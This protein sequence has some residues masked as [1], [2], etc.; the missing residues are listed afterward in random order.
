MGDTHSNTTWWGSVVRPAIRDVR[1]NAV[2][3][4]GD[5]GYWPDHDEGRAFLAEVSDSL[6]AVG[7][8][9]WFVDG[10]HEQHDRLSPRTSPHRVY[11][12]VHHLPRS[13][14]WTWESI[15]F[16]ALGGAVSPDR[17]N[18]TE[19][20]DWFES[21]RITDADLVRLGVG[22]LD[23]LVTHDAPSWCRLQAPNAPSAKVDRDTRKNRALVDRAIT[24]TAPALVLHG[25]WHLAHV[26]L[27]DPARQRPAVLGMGADGHR[28]TSVA[29][30]DVC[31]LDPS[32]RALTWSI[33]AIV[34]T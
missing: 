8:S 9:L 17:E 27:A 32:T 11:P 2:L 19:G 7:T 16:G 22:P 28:S 1:P 3:S 31:R 15:R 10:N 29:L 20:W 21:E 33:K 26:A 34:C 14:R 6:A 18:R 5:F 30:L 25:H 24:A 13:A 23:V 4:V 12:G